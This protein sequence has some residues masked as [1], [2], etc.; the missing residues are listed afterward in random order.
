MAVVVVVMKPFCVSRKK[1]EREKKG[2]S[3][4]SQCG[5]VVLPSQLCITNR[6]LEYTC[7]YAGEEKE[8]E[9]VSFWL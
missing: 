5:V 4:S 1:R 9:M 3:F 7:A 2:N 6:I 8:G